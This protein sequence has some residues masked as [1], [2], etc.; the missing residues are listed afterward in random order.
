[1]SSQTCCNICGEVVDFPIKCQECGANCCELCIV[2][3][4]NGD[5]CINCD[6]KGEES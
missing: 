2:M 4:D 5:F 1:M 3:T 6:K